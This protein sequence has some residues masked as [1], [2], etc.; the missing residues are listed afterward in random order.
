M[1]NTPKKSHIC[2][3]PKTQTGTSQLNTFSTNVPLLYP[4][5]TSENLW[6]S[7]AFRRY[8]SGTLVENALN[9]SEIIQLVLI[10]A[11]LFSNV[12]GGRERVHWE[13]SV[14]RTLLILVVAHLR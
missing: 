4:L 6:F 9:A 5:K 7:D 8:R 14:K 11:I 12:S 13:Q 1:C 3:V 10:W 2:Y